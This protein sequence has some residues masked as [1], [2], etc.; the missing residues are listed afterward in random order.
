M[1]LRELLAQFHIAIEGVDRLK[2][3][4]DKFD[5]GKT[6]AMGFGKV[7]DG[8][9]TLVPIGGLALGINRVISWSSEITE[10]VDATSKLTKTL[11]MNSLAVQQWATWVEE[12]G[13]SQ[14]SFK[15]MA[16]TLAREMQSAAGGGEAAEA[17]K[18]LG[19]EIKNA[20][21]SARSLDEVLLD[22]TGALGTMTDAG[23]KLATAQKL[24]GR[25]SVDIVGG[26]QGNREEMQKML[27]TAGELAGVYSKEFLEGSEAFNDEMSQ[28]EHQMKVLKSEIVMQILPA[29]RWWVTGTRDLI[30]TFRGFLK[31]TGILDRWT[32]ASKFLGS[33]GLLGGLIKNWAGIWKWIQKVWIL[34]RPFAMAIAKFLIWALILDDIITFLQGGE[35]ALGDLLDMIMG[36]GGAIVVLETLKALFFGMVEGIKMAFE[37]VTSLWGNLGG[38]VGVLEMLG[39][40]FMAWAEFVAT[41]IFNPIAALEKLIGLLGKAWDMLSGLGDAVGGALKG[42]ADV[43]IDAQDRKNGVGTKFL[44]GGVPQTPGSAGG[45]SVV[46][47]SKVEVN[48]TGPQT[49]ATVAA[50]GKEARSIASN[51]A[52]ANNGVRG[53]L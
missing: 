8:L 45:G 18:N 23:A 38:G 12:A 21:G 43:S 22:T 46:D 14:E 53:A 40:A 51:R 41:A 4:T 7:L 32:K 29:L 16:K 44:L 26:L 39:S 49:P 20:D 24:L 33:A 37:W 50:A 19:V 1:A 34:L 36:A 3:V 25:S 11:G 15:A 28:Q 13:G 30:R 17:F 48:L 42:I 27:V 47:N 5:A 35:S 6:S 31:E 10:A 2:E 9:K 52:R